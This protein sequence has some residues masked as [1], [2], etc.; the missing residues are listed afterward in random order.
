MGSGEREARSFDGGFSTQRPQRIFCRLS[1]LGHQ[2][3]VKITDHR[4]TTS[5]HQ[6]LT[7][8]YRDEDIHPTEI[9]GFH[10]D[11]GGSEDP[12]YIHIPVF[13]PL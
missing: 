3:S 8:D 9:G 10:A 6:L 4:L 7:T 2:L 11:I 1:V 13:R 12:R 5:D